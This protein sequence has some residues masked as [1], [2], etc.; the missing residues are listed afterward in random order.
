MKHL[1]SLSAPEPAQIFSPGPLLDLISNVS[2]AYF[3]MKFTFLFERVPPGGGGG[4]NIPGG[5]L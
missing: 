5:F 3:D 1:R 2:R 4:G